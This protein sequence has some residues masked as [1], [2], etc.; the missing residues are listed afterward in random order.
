[1]DCAEEMP[2]PVFWPNMDS[3]NVPVLARKIPGSHVGVLVNT[4]MLGLEVLKPI[5]IYLS[6][7]I[8]VRQSLTAEAMRLF[9]L[10]ILKSL[11]LTLFRKLPP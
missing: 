9:I 6:T 7:L 3:R 1:M 10:S 4:Y 8:K 5:M 11:I 2:A